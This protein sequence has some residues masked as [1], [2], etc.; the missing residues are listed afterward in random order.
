MVGL[1]ARELRKGILRICLY[2]PKHNIA[3]WTFDPPSGQALR[4]GSEWL[5]HS[6]TADG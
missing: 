3:S 4:S 2:N 6:T 1:V 5:C